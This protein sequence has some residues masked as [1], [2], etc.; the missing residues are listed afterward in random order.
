MVTQGARALCRYH[1]A[2]VTKFINLEKNPVRAA[3]CRGPR[4][5]W[6]VA[7]GVVVVVVVV[8]VVAAEGEAQRGGVRVPR[9]GVGSGR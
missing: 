3:A 2:G 8:V 7:C 9:G 5:A 4:G 6:P 1:K